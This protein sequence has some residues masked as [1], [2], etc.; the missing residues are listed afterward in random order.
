MFTVYLIKNQ[1]PKI[2]NNI[3]RQYVITFKFL[4]VLKIE[5]TSSAFVK[6]LGISVCESH[7]AQG[8]LNIIR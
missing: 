1:D 4:W 8:S 3:K 6:R 5:A 7:M 2:N